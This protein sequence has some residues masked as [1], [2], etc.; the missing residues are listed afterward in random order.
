MNHERL[1]ISGDCDQDAAT[2][3]KFSR[4][5]SAY[6]IPPVMVVAPRNEEDV[7]AVVSF[8]RNEGL[9][10]VSRSG[11]SDLSGASIGPGIVI[12]CKQYLN[13]LLAADEEAVVEPGMVLDHFVKGITARQWMLPAVPS[14][15]AVCALGGNVGTR[16]TGPRTAK[17]GTLDDFVTSL[18]FVTARG[19]VVDTARSL[20]EYLEEGL[21]RIRQ[22]FLA[23]AQ[24]RAILARRPYIAGG[25]NL[26]ALAR[27]EDMRE[28]AAHL[29]VGSVGTLGIVTRIRLRLIR[30][31][32]TRGILV[33]HFR[34]YDAL[35]A[36]ALR[37]KAL[38]PAALEFR[39]PPVPGW[40]TASF[41][42]WKTRR[43]SA[44]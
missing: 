26:K 44:P 40:S 34:D 13:R 24:S 41:S 27:C 7:S 32:P 31:Q 22:R 29:M 21:R 37:L 23:D 11:G 42:T 9:G 5:M 30:Q 14:S 17:Y 19:E 2:L 36:T 18:R 3:E 25:Y 6:R 43:S 1:I 15:S 20:P 4:D 35:T 10:I 33:A 38:A 28:L 12:N 16:S 39:M 8:A